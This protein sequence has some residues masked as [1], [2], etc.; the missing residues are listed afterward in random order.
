MFG[1]SDALATKHPSTGLLPHCPL[2]VAKD[3]CSPLRMTR[4][5]IGVLDEIRVSSMGRGEDFS[6]RSRSYTQSFGKSIPLL[7]DFA[8]SS[9][10]LC[11]NPFCR[12]SP[13][14]SQRL[15]EKV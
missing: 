11:E 4:W 9:A 1:S 3:E 7:R 15:S 8:V 10:Q 13:R 12:A 5:Y 14:Q 2:G 6:L